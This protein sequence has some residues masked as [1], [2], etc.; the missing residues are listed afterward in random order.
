MESLQGYLQTYWSNNKIDFEL[1]VNERL[2]QPT[3]MLIHSVKLFKIQKEQFEQITQVAFRGLLKLEN[4][5]TR[6][7][8]Q[9]SPQACLTKIDKLLP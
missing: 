9:P 5:K 2:K 6:D 8:L 3:D 4:S 7:I 1:L